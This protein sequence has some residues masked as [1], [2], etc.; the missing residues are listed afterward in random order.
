MSNL[1]PIAQIFATFDIM[2]YS[3]NLFEIFRSMI[4]QKGKQK[5]TVIFPKQNFLWE[6]WVICIK[7]SQ[8]MPL[9]ISWS[10]LSQE[11]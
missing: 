9:H 8:I 6:K 10:T 4:E 1:N 2:I 3:N 7:L 11:K 5:V